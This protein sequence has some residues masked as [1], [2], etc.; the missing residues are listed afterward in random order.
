MFSQLRYRRE[1]AVEA[2]ELQISSATVAEAVIDYTVEYTAHE[3][4][5]FIINLARSAL[6]AFDPMSEA[7]Q[8]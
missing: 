3:G 8:S 7:L 5:G 2:D 6:D 4:L 1:D